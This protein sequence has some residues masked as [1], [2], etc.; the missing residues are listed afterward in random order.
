MGSRQTPG[1]WRGG[2]GVD[3]FDVRNR[4]GCKNTPHPTSA[5]L[6]P[7]SPSRGEGV[8]L[9]ASQDGSRL[10]PG[11]RDRGRGGF[12]G[13]SFDAEAFLR[14]SIPLWAHPLNSSWPGLTRPSSRAF[15]LRGGPFWPP[16]SSPGVTRGEMGGSARHSVEG[17]HLRMGP[18]FRRDS[19][20]GDRAGLGM[21]LQRGVLGG[22]LR[23]SVRPIRDRYPGEGRGPANGVFRVRG[24]SF[25]LLPRV[26]GRVGL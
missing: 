4:A 10:S 22:S 17:Q 11:Q 8:V 25:R 26:R 13:W 24:G 3:P 23:L 7:P 15:R 2:S 1:G 9:A 18:G 20:I 5:S 14:L 16:G 12:W 19:G 6:R 21:E